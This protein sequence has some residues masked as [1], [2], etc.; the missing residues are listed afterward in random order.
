[1]LR[2]YNQFGEVE[3]NNYITE[4]NINKFGDILK[5]NAYFIYEYSFI[6]YVP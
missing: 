4:D 6:Q 2:Y 5:R 1:M 3:G